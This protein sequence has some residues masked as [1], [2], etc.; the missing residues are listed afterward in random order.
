LLQADAGPAILS[1]PNVVESAVESPYVSELLSIHSMDSAGSAPES[2]AVTTG[3]DVQ[4]QQE[5]TPTTDIVPISED[6]LR[7]EASL[8]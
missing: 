6:Q 3:A 7:L 5:T 2:P 4:Q 8:T 1:P